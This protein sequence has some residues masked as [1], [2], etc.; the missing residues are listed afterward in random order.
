MWCDVLKV[1][2]AKWRG[3]F[4]RFVEEGEA[5]DEFMAFLA[6]SSECRHACERILRVDRATSQMIAAAME[7]EEESGSQH[8]LSLASH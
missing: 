6:D 3:Q 5:S 4:C 8:P 1:I 2:P 7:S